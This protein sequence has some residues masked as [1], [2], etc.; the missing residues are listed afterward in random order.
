MYLVLSLVAA[1]IGYL[2]SDG[3][4]RDIPLAQLTLNKIFTAFFATLCYVAAVL[5]ASKSLKCDRIWPWRWVVV[6]RTRTWLSRSSSVRNLRRR[7]KRR[8]SL[9]YDTEAL[10]KELNQLTREPTSRHK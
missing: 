4:I 2:V 1:A 8:Q 3:S 5:L 9:G 6:R 10:Q 7:I